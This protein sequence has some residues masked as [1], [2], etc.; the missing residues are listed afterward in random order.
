M[1]LDCLEAISD[2][3]GE[4]TYFFGKDEPTLIDCALLGYTGVLLHA[5]K[6][7]NVYKLALV[8]KFPNLKRFTDN[9]LAT[10]YPDNWKELCGIKEEEPETKT[11][12]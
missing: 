9:M 5:N 7:D 10:V 12:G 11:D 3:L 6:K 2:Y 1:G 8:D 4:K